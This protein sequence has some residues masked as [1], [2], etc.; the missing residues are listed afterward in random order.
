MPQHHPAPWALALL[1][2]SPPL[3]FGQSGVELIPE[4]ATFALTIN[5]LSGLRD[6]GVKFL[7]DHGIRLKGIKPSTLF[8]IA[9]L[10]VGIRDGYDEKGPAAVVLAS[11]KK[12]RAGEKGP[13]DLEKYLYAVV[14]VKDVGEMAGNFRLNA[15]DL[16]DG[17]AHDVEGG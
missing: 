15:A 16:K 7:D 6:K 12:A 8:D 17:K 13:P 5:N 11:L 2:L 3:A 10:Y 14:P 9:F 1:L 4:D